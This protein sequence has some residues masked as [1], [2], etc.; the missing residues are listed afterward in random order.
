[1]KE[2]LAA[3]VKGLVP[4]GSVLEQTLK[5]GVW[6]SATKVAS[7]GLQ[8]LMLIVLARLLSPT[9]FGLMGIA[10]V[11]LAATRQFTEIGLNAALI[12]QKSENV[13]DYLDTTWC[14]EVGRGILITGVLVVAAPYVAAFFS[15]PRAA[16][17]IRALAVVPLLYGFRNPGI[18]YFQKDLSFHK[19]FVYKS[20]GSIVQFLVGVGYALVWPT[21]WALVFA[22]VAKQAT[23]FL[24]SYVLDDYRPWPSFDIGAARELVNYGKWITGASIAGFIYRQG[25]DAFVGWYLSATALGFYQYAYQI[26]DTPAS[27]MSNVISRITFPAFSKLQEDSEQLRNALIRTTRTTAF[28]AFPM[29]FGIAAVAPSFVP[30]ILGT[31]WTPMILTMQLL[32]IYGLLHAITANFGAVWKALNRPDYITKIGVL[33]IVCIGLLIWPATARWGIEGTAMVVVGV[34]LIV[35]FPLDVY[36]AADIVGGRSKQFYR[37]YTYPFVAAVTMFGTLWYLHR[38][39]ELSPLVEFVVSIPI[40]AVVYLAVAFVLERQ[41]DWGIEQNIQ[42]IVG[43]IR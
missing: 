10:L 39:L 41:F 29:A 27:E 13:D 24:L 25:D 42:T 33:R 32:A 4:G 15:E 22:S 21:V 37:E 38:S 11:T 19:E 6:V 14:L 17:L 31:E 18:V 9:D 40:G 23:E 12:Q 35:I 2:R 1:M 30:A 20:S 36:L 5:S 16:E 3:L 34:Y 7:R 26:A 8:L 43:G 28:V